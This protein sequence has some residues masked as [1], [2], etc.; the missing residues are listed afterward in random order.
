M[1]SNRILGRRQRNETGAA[2][3]EF[4]LILP[5][6]IVLIFALIDFGRLFFVQI[7]LTSASREA[8]R[9]SSFFVNGCV[10]SLFPDAKIDDTSSPCVL[11]D[12]KIST[13]LV[14]DVCEAVKGSLVGVEGLS[15]F[16]NSSVNEL[17]CNTPDTSS[18]K[19][20]INKPCSSDPLFK[21]TEVTI[22]VVFDWLL[23]IE[24][25]SQ[26]FVVKST[27][28]MKCLN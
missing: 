13:L 7:S 9:V 2:A 25:G 11:F 4:A 27:G 10:S 21:D 22:K 17:D 15:N 14:E 18:I 1:N 12:R 16:R 5:L 20:T 28:Y 24:I 26:P 6:V 23:P 19:V 8:V 3:V